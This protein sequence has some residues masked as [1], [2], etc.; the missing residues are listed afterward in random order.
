LHPFALP[1]SPGR[2][3]SFPAFMSASPIRSAH[4][5]PAHKPVSSNVSR[6][7]VSRLEVDRCMMNLWRRSV[8]ASS[9]KSQALISSSISS[10]LNSSTGE[11]L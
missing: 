1:A 7:A 4:S 2:M 5:S 9:Q 10:F 6:M 11:R 8:T 3:R